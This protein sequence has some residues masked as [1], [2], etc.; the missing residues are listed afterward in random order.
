MLFL[1]ELNDEQV[2]QSIAD[3]QGIKRHKIDEVVLC[4]HICNLLDKYFT[5]FSVKVRW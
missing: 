1:V 3:I 4:G 5:D 2:Y